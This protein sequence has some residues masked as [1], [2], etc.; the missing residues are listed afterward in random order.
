MTVIAP[1]VSGRLQFS[2]RHIGPQP[3]ERD[4]MLAALGLTAAE[5]EADRDALDLVDEV[6]GIPCGGKDWN[7]RVRRW[8]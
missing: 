6:M 2:A 4:T 3:D 1:P 8:L 7:G 5:A